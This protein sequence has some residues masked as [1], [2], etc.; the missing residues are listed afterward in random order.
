VVLAAGVLGAYFWAV[1][2][3]GPGPRA[4]TLA[5]MALVL[6][7][8]VQAMRC[9][10][11][12]VGWWRLPFNP[13]SWVALATLVGV[14]CLAVSVPSLAH[15]RSGAARSAGLALVDGERALARGAPRAR[16][17]DAATSPMGLACPSRGVSTSERVVAMAQSTPASAISQ[18]SAV[19]RH[20]TAVAIGTS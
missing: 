11:E 14:Q 4:T 2:E 9:R 5:F 19:N 20:G 7:H 12:R 3:A 18:P 10:S 15:P 1:A 17:A 8:P 16:R 6:I 13:L